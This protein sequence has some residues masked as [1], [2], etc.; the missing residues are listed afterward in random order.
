MIT[1][2]VALAEV[3]AAFVTEIGPVPVPGGMVAVIT[4]SELIEKIVATLPAKETSVTPVKPDP[5]SRML[6]PTGAD[7][8]AK[9]TTTGGTMTAK[10]APELAV[11]AGFVTSIAPVAAP[12][13]TA[14]VKPAAPVPPKDTS[15]TLVKPA[16]STSTIAPTIPCPGVKETIEGGAMNVKS[17]VEIA[18]PAAFVT[19]MGPVV[20]PAGTVHVITPSEATVKALAGVPLKRSA[21]APV[22]PEPESST[23]VPE[24]PSSGSKEAMEGGT[25]TTNSA[26]ALDVPAAFVNSITP[27]DAPAGTVA[28]ITLSEE[29]V[30]RLAGVPPKLTSVTPVKPEPR[31]S[32]EAPIGPSVGSKEV[33][34]GTTITTNSAPELAVPAT[35][36]TSITPVVAPA[37][38]VTAR[39]LSERIVKELA[40]VPPNTTSV[41]VVKLV[42]AT[43][44]ELPMIAIAGVKEATQ[45]G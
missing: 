43:S 13:G 27:V 18:V 15:V 42:P 24:G 8:G 33:I 7:G 34:E 32:T 29:T 23:G 41:T 38:T 44:T 5:E 21:V 26:A 37:G 36:V 45:G 10:S 30:N 11:P 3:P 28:V 39:T 14:A 25:I 1:R 16:P 19:S 31:S 4:L 20:A 35:F 22:K 40:G 6:V 2:S 9:E 12:A 17:V